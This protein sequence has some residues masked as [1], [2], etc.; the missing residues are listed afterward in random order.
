[1][2]ITDR[3]TAG[4]PETESAS[5]PDEAAEESTPLSDDDVFHILQTS[6]RREAIRY[7]L[8]SEGTVKMGN[9]AE[10]VAAREHD[11]TVAKLT[12][13]QRQ[14][15][16]IPL[17]QSHLPKLDKA[18]VIEY[19]K[20]RGIIRPG[21]HLETFR[22]YLEVTMTD[23]PADESESLWSRL[24]GRIDTDE[25]YYI[26]TATASVGLLLAAAF[27]LLPISGLTLGTIITTL[28][29]LTTFACADDH[30]L[31]LSQVAGR[32]RS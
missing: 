23:A 18:G 8:D 14:R 15:V 9:L 13:T 11:T 7:V 3:P 30:R 12:S 20:S 24:D 1:M 31:V 25:T 32:R 5:P 2:S 4:D 29:V 17:Y 21:A 27:G 16:Y 6:R 19:N 26:A 28:F 10:H 22:P